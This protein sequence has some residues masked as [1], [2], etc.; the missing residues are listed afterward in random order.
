VE[1]L[2][3]ALVVAGG[4]KAVQAIGSG[5]KNALQSPATDGYSGSSQTP[6]SGVGSP[7]SGGSSSSSSEWTSVSVK[8][9]INVG[10]YGQ[11]GILTVQFTRLNELAIE[12]GGDDPLTLPVKIHSG[13]ISGE[14]AHGE[15]TDSITVRAGSEWQVTLLKHS[16]RF[17]ATGPEMMITDTDDTVY[18]T[19]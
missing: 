8:I 13:A 18:T 2:V 10:D 6:S 17:T 16:F 5:I 3:T 11:E 4:I 12:S 9:D 15:S 7:S 1:H 19:P 14:G